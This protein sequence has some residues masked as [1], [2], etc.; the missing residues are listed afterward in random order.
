MPLSSSSFGSPAQGQSLH[1]PTPVPSVFYQCDCLNSRVTEP[2][3]HRT[4]GDGAPSQPTVD[5]TQ[6]APS[7]G[8]SLTLSRLE[9]LYYCDDCHK[10]RCKRCISEE[11]SCF[12]CPNCLFEVPTASAKA[13]KN[14]CARNCFQC[15]IC[16]NTLTVVSIVD[17]GAAG[18]TVSGANIHYLSCGVCRWDSLEIGLK[19]ERPTGLAMQLQKAEDER[20]DVK[21]FESLRAYF[22]KAMKAQGQPTGVLKSGGAINSIS[23]SLL[24]SIPGLASLGMGL[25][26]TNPLPIGRTEELEPYESYAKEFPDNSKAD[27]E[28]PLWRLDTVTTL[29]QRLNQPDDEPRRR[30]DLRPQ[31][32]QLRTK[33]SKR[34]RQCDHFLIKPEIKAVATRFKIKLIAREFL[35]TITIAQPMPLSPLTPDVPVKLLLKFTNPID[36]EMDVSIATPFAPGAS[37]SETDA[38]SASQH[39]VVTVLA[40]TFTIPPHNEM[41]QY[42]EPATLPSQR[43][44]TASTAA[45]D[46]LAGAEEGKNCRTVMLE[47]IPKKGEGEKY[48]K[49]IEFPLLVTFA[50]LVNKTSR[51][52]IA[53]VLSSRPSTTEVSA[54]GSSIPSSSID[55][56]SKLKAGG[57]GME[58][59][60]NSFWIMV[61]VGELI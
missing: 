50:R 24:A 27:E 30:M 11:I 45:L 12:Y 57:D 37:K 17:P 22:E 33:R 23:S 35:P 10:I 26:K 46:L 55:S 31:R 32:I 42:D 19:F 34:C 40:P 60:T 20:S 18:A 4:A 29:A 39:C 8:S 16:M 13:E 14:R 2:S 28:D 36:Q 15:P 48:S 7:E 54:A 61:G 41:W 59:R 25:P 47:V 53:E 6:N 43:G 49:R 52:S 5:I 3:A 56:V 51:A 58:K 44:R 1:V 9:H 38:S 21:E